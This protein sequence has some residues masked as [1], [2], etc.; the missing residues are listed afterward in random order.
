LTEN[1]NRQE[2]ELLFQLEA[3]ALQMEHGRKVAIYSGYFSVGASF[4]V[5]SLT[6]AIT[7]LLVEK[8]LPFYWT[9]LIFVY[10]FTGAGFIAYS[11]AGFGKLKKTEKMGL[12]V[13]KQ[14]IR[15]SS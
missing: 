8:G 13:L 5:F 3:M 4:E 9:I 6:L 2:K 11:L 14:K 1:T 15:G 10:F 12:E 7:G